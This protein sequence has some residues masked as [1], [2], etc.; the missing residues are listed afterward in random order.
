LVLIPSLVACF[1]DDF[2]RFLGRKGGVDEPSLDGE[3]CPV[4][5]PDGLHIR[6]G[7][8]DEGGSAPCCLVCDSI[9]IE[10]ARG[11]DIV[12]HMLFAAVSWHFLESDSEA[13]RS[14][15]GARFG[16]KLQDL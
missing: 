1:V 15:V 12:L 16:G 8:F 10:V 7:D 9:S 11:E 3:G 14:Y 5:F 13:S 2:C 6:F 4:D